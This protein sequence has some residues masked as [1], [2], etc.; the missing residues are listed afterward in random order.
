MIAGKARTAFGTVCLLAGALIAT[1]EAAAY[2]AALRGDDSALPRETGLLPGGLTWTHVGSTVAALLFFVAAALFGSGTYE[3]LVSPRSSRRRRAAD[4]SGGSPACVLAIGTATPQ[5]PVKTEKLSRVCSQEL[6]LSDKVASWLGDRC[7]ASGITQRW[8]VV[9]GI[10]SQF[11][12]GDDVKEGLYASAPDSNPTAGAR[13]DVWAEEAP[14]LAIEAAREAMANFKGTRA[15]ISHV[16]VHS[17][18][19]FKA[20][21]IELDVIDALQLP[22][23]R[24]R[25]GT[26]YMGCFGGFTVLS[27]AKAFCESEP[28]S[29]VL[30]VCVELCTLHLSKEDHRS[31]G[32][33]N[34]IFGD[35]AAAAVVGPGGVGDW[36]LGNGASVTLRSE[37]R[38][39]MTWKPTD[40]GHRMW[41]DKTIGYELG[42]ALRSGWKQWLQDACGTKTSKD[43]EWAVHPGGK[44]ILEAVLDSR[45]GVGIER[46]DL[47]HS[48]DVLSEN[49]NMSSATILFVLRRAMK[50]TDRRRIFA[51][52]FGPGLT[53]EYA[54]LHQLQ[55]AGQAG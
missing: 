32:I 42:V 51:M 1:A 33:G 31:V 10:D 29:H 6:G 46:R 36:A 48:F 15:D 11:G 52:G 28:G 20:P 3:M 25:L 16:I 2:D 55:A 54:G 26:N 43:V 27:T 44:G 9:N 45:V 30:V 24:R 34:I 53:L 35:G 19:G 38:G 21:G 23:V 12:G 50:Q 40:F 7:E 8:S 49:G 18:T 14:K 47:R 4:V 5:Y 41:L 37:T 13:G 39:A 17:C 22:N